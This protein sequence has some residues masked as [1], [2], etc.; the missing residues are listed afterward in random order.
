[1]RPDQTKAR[2]L[3]TRYPTHLKCHAYKCNNFFFVAEF[4]IE[5]GKPHVS[6]FSSSENMHLSSKSY[7]NYKNKMEIYA[8]DGR[9]CGKYL[10]ACMCVCLCQKKALP[11]VLRLAAE[12][13]VTSQHKVITTKWYKK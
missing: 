12:T 6:S 9:V 11:A 10:T 4:F 1:M 13:A 8:A 3:D 2:Y 5:Y 7:K